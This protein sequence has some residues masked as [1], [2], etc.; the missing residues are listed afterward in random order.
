MSSLAELL[1][2]VPETRH[3]G[4]P[5]FAQYGF[6]RNPFPAARTIIEQVLYN[7]VEA[8]DKFVGL[9]RDVLSSDAP[10]RRAIGVMGGTGG[11]K[12]HFLR[13]CQHQMRE[14]RVQLKRPFV[15]AEVLAGSTSAIQVLREIL[16]E[17][18]E[19]ARLA[20]EFDL[21]TAIIRAAESPF[22]FSIVR[23]PE[24][25]AVLELLYSS[26]QGGFVPPDR[27]QKMGFEPL[28]DLAKKWLN[29][30][31]LSQTE[32]RYLGV[33]SRLGSAAMMT[34]FV[35]ELFSLA[36]KKDLIEGVML[37]IDEIETLFSGSFSSSKVQGFLQDLRYFFDEAVRGQEGYS[38]LVMSASTPFGTANLR[39]YNYPLYQRLGF[40]EGTRAELRPISNIHEVREIAQ[41]YIDYE[42]DRA[43]LRKSSNRKQIVTDIDLESAYGSAASTDRQSHSA[44]V[45][46][47]NQGQ[48]L[49]ALHEIVELKR[50]GARD[51]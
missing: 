1:G 28:R 48:L 47:V 14:Y 3:Q 18:D 34:R 36:R 38:L 22:D 50:Q 15:V 21:I 16:R 45:Q 20:G 41:L 39:N 8:R 29:G 35:A 27:D 12:T 9:V 4:D 49:Q 11:G 25:R 44:P 33:F 24:L 13:Y 19:T 30:A 17:A 7:Q 32:K 26:T 40:E 37:C 42:I 31:P 5:F 46:R 10:Q 43:Q 2:N 23:Q 6:Q 51:P